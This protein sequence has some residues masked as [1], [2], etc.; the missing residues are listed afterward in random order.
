MICC[1]TVSLDENII[2]I[3]S[4][5]TIKMSKNKTAGRDFMKDFVQAASFPVS[6]D[7]FITEKFRKYCYLKGVQHAVDPKMMLP[8]FLVATSNCMGMAKL[9]FKKSWTVSS[10]FYCML[11][12]PKASGKT[13]VSGNSLDPLLA[14]ELEDMEEFDDEKM[15]AKDR[16][17]KGAKSKETTAEMKAA[18]YTSDNDIRKGKA[19]GNKETTAEMKA[20]RYTS[21]NERDRYNIRKGKANGNGDGSTDEGDETDYAEDEEEVHY[22][23]EEDDGLDSEQEGGL[24]NEEEEDRGVGVKTSSLF[25]PR[26][27]IVSGITPEA[28]I[29]TLRYCEG[30]L[31]LHCDEWKGFVDRFLSTG[32][33]ESILCSLFTGGQLKYTTIARGAITIADTRVSILGCIQPG[34]LVEMFNRKPD[35]QGFHDRFLYIAAAEDFESD[36]PDQTFDI[37]EGDE[38]DI[39]KYLK[40]VRNS[41]KGPRVYTVTKEAMGSFVQ[42]HADL[43][44]IS[45]DTGFGEE[46]RSMIKKNFVILQ[47]VSMIMCCARNHLS[48]P[49]ESRY[50]VS[51]QDVEAAWSLIQSSMN[52]FQTFKDSLLDEKSVAETASTDALEEEEITEDVII[53]NSMKISQIYAKAVND[54]ILLSVLSRDKLDKVKNPGVT[55]MVFLRVSRLLLFYYSNLLV[56]LQPQ[57]IYDVWQISCFL[58]T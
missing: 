6:D 4:D 38:V 8:A 34:P 25:H 21:D 48:D 30:A 44:Q 43:K 41:H 28:M 24:D 49:V 37:Q 42:H 29:E 10:N 32:M 11:V 5:L 33:F 1:V 17:R 23:S 53:S 55:P 20:A 22:A 27:R 15:K 51:A 18:R 16:K 40:S 26:T 13:P 12:A 7:I 35:N 45:K 36:L 57:F 9:E 50:E 14:L 54:E 39:F 56:L 52:T 2:N 3:I 19:N 58:L 47:K 46:T 31:L